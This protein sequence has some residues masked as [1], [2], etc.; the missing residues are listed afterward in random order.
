M[1]VNAETKF[2]TVSRWLDGIKSWKRKLLDY[3]YIIHLLSVL[4]ASCYHQWVVCLRRWLVHAAEGYSHLQYH[5]NAQPDQSQCCACFSM[6]HFSEHWKAHCYLVVLELCILFV[7]CLLFALFISFG[8]LWM[9]WLGWA[10]CPRHCCVEANL[11]D[12]LCFAI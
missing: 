6:E 10:L 3:M 4:C 9:H 7:H 8:W 11:L 5:I 12:K 1:H 2:D